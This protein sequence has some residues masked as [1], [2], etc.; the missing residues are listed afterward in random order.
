MTLQCSRVDA[1]AVRLGVGHG[2]RR[3]EKGRAAQK[4]LSR[5]SG[6]EKQHT[7]SPPRMPWRGPCALKASSRRQPQRR[8]EALR[9]RWTS[10]RS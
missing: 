6:C 4:T 2:V 9:R 3:R 1:D 10:V 8:L 5:G 7:P